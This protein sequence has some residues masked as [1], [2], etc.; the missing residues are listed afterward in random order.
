M[1]NILDNSYNTPRIRYLN[2]N[3]HQVAMYQSEVC[4]VEKLT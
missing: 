3:E 1:K 4:R 2:S